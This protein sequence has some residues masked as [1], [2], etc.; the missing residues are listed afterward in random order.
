MMSALYDAYDLAVFAGH[1]GLQWQVPN[2]L[3]TAVLPYKSPAYD[4][5]PL[6]KKLDLSG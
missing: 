5:A 1:T 4:F 3:P 6:R 2:F